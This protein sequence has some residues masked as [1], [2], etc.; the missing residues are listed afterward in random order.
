MGFEIQNGYSQNY[1][2][3]I[4]IENSS[5]TIDRNVIHSNTAGN[6]GGGGGGIAV[7]G[8]SYPHMFGNEIFDNTV[9]GDC[10]C[11][12]Y[13]GGGIYVDSLAWPI[14]GGSTTI[15][16]IF[17]DN[18]ADVG[19]ALYKNFSVDPYVWDQIYAHHNY[20]EECPPDS[21]GLTS[22]TSDDFVFIAGGPD[23]P[24]GSL[25]FVL[26]PGKY[27]F[28]TAGKDGSTLDEQLVTI[29]PEIHLAGFVETLLALIGLALLLGASEMAFPL[30]EMW[31]R[32]REA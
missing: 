3:G 16:N 10:D 8:L 29:E 31:K 27:R 19:K 21:N 25:D 5:P 2:G 28:V 12:C 11:I 18:Y 1:G 14:L 4:L 22:C 26:E 30:R 20:F 9:Q 6:C 24:D 32:F 23:S 7:L 15:G 13:F 17:Y